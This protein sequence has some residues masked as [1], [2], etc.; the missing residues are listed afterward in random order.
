MNYKKITTYARLYST[1]AQQA[2]RV[3][4]LEIIEEDDQTITVREIKGPVTYWK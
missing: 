2:A 3:L 1:T 4:G